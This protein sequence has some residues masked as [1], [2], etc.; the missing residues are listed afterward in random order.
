MQRWDFEPAADFGLSP[1]ARLQSLHR[2]AGLVGSLVHLGWWAL[3]RTYLAGFHRLAIVGRE[4]LPRRAPF[5]L[6]ANHASHLD[7]VS[8]AACLPARHCHR[9]FP[10]AAG[11][12]F[13]ES[14]GVSVF[15]AMALNALPLWRRKARRDDLAMLRTRLG[16]GGCIYILFPE[17]T[18]ARDG[19]MAG[20]KPGIGRLVA[21][22]PVPVVPCH[23]AGAFEAFPPQRKLPRP[24]RLR[25]TIG[26]PL[27]F[28]E[29]Q[30]DKAGWLHVAET[31]EAAV[32][33]LA[34]RS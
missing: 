20:F 32:R 14:F 24:R 34:K 15:A 1:R 3:S 7:A 18:R 2:E 31:T 13:F 30:D 10:I 23:I 19:V 11:D 27:T 5:I 29:T 33:Q 26:T 17:G 28:A 9:T 25:I 21:G 8:L 6:V 4:N 16:E 22:T 12:T